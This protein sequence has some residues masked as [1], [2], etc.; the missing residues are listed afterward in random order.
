ML[1]T[2]SKGTWRLYREELIEANS[3]FAYLIDADV[4]GERG[5]AVASERDERENPDDDKNCNK[6]PKMLKC[7]TELASCAGGNF[8]TDEE[9]TPS[10]SL[11]GEAIA[12]AVA[13]PVSPVPGSNP[14]P[15]PNRASIQFLINDKCAPSSS[16]KEDQLFPASFFSAKANKGL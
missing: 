10:P 1:K 4:R 7:C 5:N 8:A 9:F 11:S 3:P 6:K 15:K 2:C 12:S 13:E 16:S 14:P